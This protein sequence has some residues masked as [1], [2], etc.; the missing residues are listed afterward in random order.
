MCYK[1]YHVINHADTDN[2]SNPILGA[3][4]TRLLT[5]IRVVCHND[6]EVELSINSETGKWLE[7]PS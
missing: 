2:Y 6:L 3:S 7:G 5:I 1:R 4:I